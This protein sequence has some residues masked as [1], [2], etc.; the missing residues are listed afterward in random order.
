MVPIPP[1]WPVPQALSKIQRFGAPHLT[2]R[3]A[4]RAE[5]QRGA[6]EI[7]ERCHPVFG[8]QSHQV[9]RGTLQFA[10]IFDQDDAIARLRDLCEK[11]VGQRGLAGRRPARD[12][13]VSSPCDGLA[14]NFGFIGQHDAGRDIVVEREHRDR[15]FTNGEGGRRHD[16]RKQSLKTLT[17]F[18]QFGGD[19]RRSRMRLNTDMMGDQ[20]NDPFAVMRR[21]SFTRLRQTAGQPVD[22]EPPIGIQHH[23]DDGRVFQPLRNGWSERGAQHAR[24]AQN[25]RCSGVFPHTAAPKTVSR[26]HPTRS[27]VGSDKSRSGAGSGNASGAG[28]V[29][30][31]RNRNARRTF[32]PPASVR[33]INVYRRLKARMPVL[34]ST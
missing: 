32:R 5:A 17:G 20:A 29:V 33:T 21:Q 13:D 19:P 15:W 6:D 2:D 16:R 26:D 25:N 11:R 18:R 9:W 12:K 27:N 3:N 14:Q 4:V 24:A 10:R 8:P 34:H 28:I 22:P 1:G 30:W 7:G 23:F 31:R